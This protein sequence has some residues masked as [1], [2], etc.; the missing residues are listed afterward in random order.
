MIQIRNKYR[1]ERKEGWRSKSERI[2]REGNMT[3]R[4]RTEEGKG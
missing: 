2:K 1:D 4:R 3:K